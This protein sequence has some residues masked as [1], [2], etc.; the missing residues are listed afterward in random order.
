MTADATSPTAHPTAEPTS[1]R[2]LPMH[3]DNPRARSPFVPV[4]PAMVM[5]MAFAVLALVWATWGGDLPGGRWLAV[6]LFTLGVLTTLVVALT[7]HFAQTLLHTPERGRVTPRLALVGGGA[8]LV[9]VGLP[10]DR[11]W[12]VGVGAT[13]LAAAVLWLYTDLRRMRRSSLTGRFPFVVRTYER[14]CSAFIHGALLGALMGVGALSGPWYGAARMAHLHLNILGW[15]GLTLLGTI[16]FFAPTVMRARMEPEADVAAARWLG[17]GATGLS[18][19]ALGMLLTGLGGAWAT[20][21]GLLAA[22]G[23]VVYA[24]GVAAVCLPVVRTGRRARSRHAARMLQATC[25]WFMIAVSADVVVVATGQVRLLEPLG[26][27]MLVGVLGQAV[28]T[29]L[30]YLVP[31]AWA[32]GGPG[33][34]AALD[35]LAVWS[36]MRVA[37]LNGGLGL[38]AAAAAVGPAGGATWSASARL[39]WLLVLTAV[40]LQLVLLAAAVMHPTAGS[41]GSHG[42]GGA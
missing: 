16:V 41:G 12:L 10:T 9:L 7:H 26:A 22:S 4:R 27:V 29:A 37:M 5:A 35:R 39:G 28:L 32:Q 21:A 1:M 13:A 8:V 15:G 30:A 18:V 36:R 19:A 17:R 31:M 40:V 3:T 23:L 25:A 33:R 2:D 14:A 11:R 42:H 24:I 38:V 20:A 34:A 6:H